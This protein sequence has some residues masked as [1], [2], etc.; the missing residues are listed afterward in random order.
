[1]SYIHTSS[2]TNTHT[3]TH[4]HT[5]HEHIAIPSLKYVIHKTQTDLKNITSTLCLYTPSYIQRL[6][7]RT[8][9]FCLTHRH[10]YHMHMHILH[11]SLHHVIHT[12]H[13]HHTYKPRTRPQT[14]TTY[15][16]TYHLYTTSYIQQAHLHTC[17]FGLKTQTHQHIKHNVHMYQ[18]TRT[19]MYE[20]KHDVCE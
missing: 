8:S 12:Q 1:M 7:Q 16:S 11:L 15:T 17:M 13:A 2:Y 5:P 6:I 4:T 10:T 14:C 18:R 3:H 19:C 9:T 20:C